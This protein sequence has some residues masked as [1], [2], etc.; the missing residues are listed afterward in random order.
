[1]SFNRQDLLR[2]TRERRVFDLDTQEILP[3]KMIEVGCGDVD[4]Q[5]L[6]VAQILASIDELNSGKL[7]LLMYLIAESKGNNVVLATTR[8]LA[9][10]LGMSRTTVMNTL[11]ILEK[12][13]IIQRRPGVVFVSPSVAFKGPAGK[14]MNVL[15]R[16]DRAVQ[17]KEMT[18][19]ERKERTRRELEGLKAREEV[20]RNELALLEGKT[21]GGEGVAAEKDVER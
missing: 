7:K 20:L 11:K 3:V 10:G 4:F 19:E 17:R 2:L 12:H 13:Q 5:K 14:R 1:M 16:Y 15:V 9:K 8:E 18:D 21:S 6:W